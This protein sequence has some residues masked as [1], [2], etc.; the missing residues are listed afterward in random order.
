RALER[1]CPA[2]GALGDAV[3]YAALSPGKRIRPLLA[4]ASC[5]GAGGPWRAALPAGAALEAIHAYSL[6][7]DDL[8]AMDDDDF[9]RGLPTTHKKYGEAMAIL[10]GDALLTLAFETIAAPTQFQPDRL[11]Q[12]ILRLSRALG[13]RDGMISGQVLDL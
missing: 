1:R 12:A 3:R 8:P 10:A 9:R 11:N 4:M 13:T 6:I 5:E 7:Q 2:P